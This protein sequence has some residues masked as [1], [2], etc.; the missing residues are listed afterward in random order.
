MALPTVVQARFNYTS[1]GHTITI[2]RYTGPGGA[3][4]IQATII[5]LP[6]TRIGNNAFYGNTNLTSVTIPYSVTDIGGVA[7]RYCTSLSAITVNAFNSVYS[8]VDGVLFNKSQT[9]LIHMPD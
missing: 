5:G 1:D 6:V 4:V 7:F 8:S 3:V 2:I 9:V